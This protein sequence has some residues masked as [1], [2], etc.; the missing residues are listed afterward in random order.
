MESIIHGQVLLRNPDKEVLS[1]LDERGLFFLL[2][3]YLTSPDI[4]LE[5]EVPKKFEDLFACSSSDQP[6]QVWI[7]VRNSPHLPHMLL[8]YRGT[9][10][11]YAIWRKQT[12]K[13]SS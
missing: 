8:L 7:Q 6:E 5:I 13:S 4:E 3:D 11:S 12:S 10:S 9:R 2:S 1:G